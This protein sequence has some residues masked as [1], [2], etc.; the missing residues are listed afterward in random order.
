MARTEERR[1]A[2]DVTFD[3]LV[4]ADRGSLP[5]AART[6]ATAGVPVFPCL[7]EQKRPLT[8]RG[9]HDATDDLG[10]VSAWWARSPEANIAIPTGPASGVEVVDVDV[11]PGGSGYAAFERA[12][13]E[14]LVDGWL[15]LV[16]TPSGG[17]H[18]YYPAGGLE[19]RSWQ[20]PGAHVDFRGS[21][22]YVVA[23]PSRVTVGADR[24]GGYELIA[25]TTRTPTPIDAARLRD[26][27]D[28]RPPVILPAAGLAQSADAERLGRWVS[29][30]GEGERNRGLFWAACRLA[31]AGSLPG[32]ALAVLG[33]AAEHAGLGSREV[34]AT[35]RS[36]YRTTAPHAG[37]RVSFSPGGQHPMPRRSSRSVTGQV[38]S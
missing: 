18:A 12:R 35:I 29:S 36:A 8:K 19:Q 32:E 26:F 34:S 14:G 31:E 23:P 7:P 24:V 30:L 20:A 15:A 10:Q 17:L 25:T 2:R 21:G 37:D 22:G 33:P 4:G 5:E 6:Y 13:R 27:L 1:A 3:A 28:P 11:H 38:L 16:R 9:F